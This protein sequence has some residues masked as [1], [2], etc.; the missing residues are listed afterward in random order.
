MFQYPVVLDLYSWCPEKF[1]GLAKDQTDFH[2][3]ETA[4]ELSENL[5][6]F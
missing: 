2:F 5:M 6:F 3:L 4:S 1:F